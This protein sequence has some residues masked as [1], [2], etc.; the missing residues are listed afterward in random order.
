MSIN[1]S[2]PIG[3]FQAYSA[4]GARPKAL[5]VMILIL[6]AMLGFYYIQAK[7]LEHWS[8]VDTVIDRADV[9][10]RSRRGVSGHWDINITCA[11]KVADHYYEH[12]IDSYK[13][14][15]YSQSQAQTTADALMHTKLILLYDPANPGHS[16]TEGEVSSNHVVAPVAL[17]G[18]LISGVI[19]LA[20]LTVGL[21]AD[22][23]HRSYTAN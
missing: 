22:A 21:M 2:A 7:G 14:W 12:N 11:Y 19:G 3:E 8:Q 16:L 17:G 4:P 9:T 5:G 15:I 6:T 13:S 18:M 1:P 20:F 10:Y 23:A